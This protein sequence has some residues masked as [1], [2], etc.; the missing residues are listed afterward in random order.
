MNRKELL[1]YHRNWR[2]LHPHYSK[3]RIDKLKENREND[4]FM[5]LNRY[6]DVVAMRC[7]HCQFIYTTGYKEIQF[8][9]LDGSELKIITKTNEE[10]K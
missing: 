9:E 7:P 2:R 6:K 5:V 10:P 1:E 3:N 4:K 8:C